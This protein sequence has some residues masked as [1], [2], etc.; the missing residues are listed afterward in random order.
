MPYLRWGRKIIFL[1][2][3]LFWH[4]Y[5][6]LLFYSLLWAFSYYNNMLDGYN[7]LIRRYFWLPFSDYWRCFPFN[8]SV[9]LIVLLLKLFIS[10][11]L[12]YFDAWSVILIIIHECGDQYCSRDIIYPFRENFVN[13]SVETY[14]TYLYFWY[15]LI[16]CSL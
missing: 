1:H 5:L 9:A 6:P 2:T 10:T 4:R 15:S 11:S 12:Y 3:L 14:L 7:I 13:I 8:P 16:I